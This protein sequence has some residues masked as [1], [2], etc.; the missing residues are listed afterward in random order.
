VISYFLL[1][2]LFPKDAKRPYP[3]APAKLLPDDVYS[4]LGINRVNGREMGTDEEFIV[5]LS[6]L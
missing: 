2:K 6:L 1:R 4:E 3:P 5:I